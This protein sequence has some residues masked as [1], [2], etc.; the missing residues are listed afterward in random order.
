MAEPIIF[1][2]RYLTNQGNSQVPAK[3]FPADI[4]FDIDNLVEVLIEAGK[5]NAEIGKAV[6][7]KPQV[8]DVDTPYASCLM[9]MVGL[10]KSGSGPGSNSFR[11]SRLRRKRD[12]T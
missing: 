1:N 9:E 11:L 2:A 4:T 5:A 8:F 3:P 10:A 6:G 12:Q 7:T